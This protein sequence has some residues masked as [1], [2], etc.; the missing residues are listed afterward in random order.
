M[1]R[2]TK[3]MQK[4]PELRSEYHPDDAFQ[5]G[6]T[7]H[8]IYSIREARSKDSS[9]VKPE[10]TICCISDM[11]QARFIWHGKACCDLK[12]FLH[13]LAEKRV[14]LVEK[15]GKCCCSF[16][17]VGLSG[18]VEALR[19]DAVL[20]VAHTLQYLTSRLKLSFRSLVQKR[21]GLLKGCLQVTMQVQQWAFL[22]I[23][24][25]GGIIGLILRTI[26]RMYNLLFFPALVS[27]TSAFAVAL[28][29]ACLIGIPVV[30]A[31][32]FDYIDRQVKTGVRKLHFAKQRKEFSASLHR[33]LP[34][35]LRKYAWCTKW[36]FRCVQYS[37]YGTTLL[38]KNYSDHQSTT[39]SQ[40]F[41]RLYGRSKL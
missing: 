6:A 11:E 30:F 22:P 7:K 9:D 39:R 41:F 10:V 16:S 31:K 29:M 25:P 40:N 17:G 26:L 13:V 4:I 3:A 34:V 19:R 32:V 8:L 24:A 27:V 15:V 5:K 1:E 28:G 18:I 2:V 20:T 21:S 37:I 35:L 12:Y 23:M 33:K 14:V 38:A 36:L